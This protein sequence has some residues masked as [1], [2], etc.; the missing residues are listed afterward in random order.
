MC[1]MN[2]KAP[3]DKTDQLCEQLALELVADRSANNYLCVAPRTALHRET[4][5]PPKAQ[6]HSFDG[7]EFRVVVSGSMRVT[8]AAGVVDLSPGQLLLLGPDVTREDASGD[9][10]RPY[11]VGWCWINKSV[12]ILGQTQYNP[13]SALK[14]GPI[15]RLFR[16]N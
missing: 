16:S 2:G 3:D 6:K 15:V 11:V 4:D 8:T 14:V 1:P 12:A 10:S 7:H 9:V 5:L 13:P